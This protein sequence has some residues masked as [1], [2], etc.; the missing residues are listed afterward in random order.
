MFGQEGYDGWPQV[1]IG[2]LKS[3]AVFGAF[4]LDQFIQRFRCR[5]Y[6]FIAEQSFYLN[7]ARGFAKRTE[8]RLP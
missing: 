6:A 7:N 1:A 2:K 3:E 4:D 5:L 8:I